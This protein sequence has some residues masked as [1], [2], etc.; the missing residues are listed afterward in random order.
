MFFSLID[1]VLMVA[2]LVVVGA[3]WRQVDHH[4]KILMPWKELQQ[5]PAPV[6]KTLLLDYISPILPT[7]LWAAIKNRHWAVVM[8]TVGHLLILGTV[9]SST[10]PQ[11][12][13]RR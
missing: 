1:H 12:K 2:V 4:N 5:G 6:H 3:L 7:S 9:R 10:P 13:N 8:S 11:S